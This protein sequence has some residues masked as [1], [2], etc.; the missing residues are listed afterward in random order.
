MA[1]KN[2]GINMLQKS[3]DNEW[4]TPESAIQMLEDH[5]RQSKFPPNSN[6]TVWECFGKDFSYI[7]SPQYIKNLGYNVIADGEDF[8]RNCKGDLVISNGPYSTPKGERNIKER[9]IE[10]LC[11]LN[12]PFCLLMPT[13]YLQTK[14][15]KKMV[16]KYGNFQFIVPCKKIQFY[17]VDLI[18]KEKLKKNNCSFY[19]CWYCW[20][21]G[22]QNDFTML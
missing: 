4:Y 19:T 6:T 11:E 2:V 12:I 9:I 1:K 18:T 17:K 10:R 14:S 15:F 22:F 13:S 8:W 3:S 5:L 16:D 20:N 21:M 7:E